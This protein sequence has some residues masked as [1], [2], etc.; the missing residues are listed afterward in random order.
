VSDDCKSRF[1]SFL[2]QSDFF[3]LVWHERSESLISSVISSSSRW[4]LA[5]EKGDELSLI[6]ISYFPSPLVKSRCWRRSFQLRCQTSSSSRCGIEMWVLW[7]ILS[8]FDKLFL[9]KLLPLLLSTS[10]SSPI[11]SSRRFKW[12]WRMARFPMDEGFLLTSDLRL[13]QFLHKQ[14]IA[15]RDLKASP[16]KLHDSPWIS[17]T[18]VSRSSLLFL[19]PENILLLTSGSDRFPHIQLGDFGLAFQAVLPSSSATAATTPKRK[20]GRPKK[21]DVEEKKEALPTIRASSTCGT[22]SYLPPE[23]FMIRV[24]GES[25]DPLKVSWKSKVELCS[26][27]DLFHSL[28]SHFSF[29]A[30]YLGDWM[31][32][33]RE[34]RKIVD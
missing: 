33:L 23:A 5:S 11:K 28:W 9:I 4:Q 3:G 16:D 24:T 19:Q 32:P 15:H 31:Y 27:N 7:S 12:V 2:L 8:P 29:K 14:G 17:L 34:L 13:S 22:V 21:A 30:R 20:P 1:R 26:R 18:S 6:S 25:Y 10:Q